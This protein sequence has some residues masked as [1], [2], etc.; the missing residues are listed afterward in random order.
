MIQ[1]REHFIDLFYAEW[2]VLLAKSLLTHWSQN[3]ANKLINHTMLTAYGN[4]FEFF[5]HRRLT[6]VTLIL[7]KYFWSIL[8]WYD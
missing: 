2:V 8:R 6:L 4:R 1:R 3:I 7:F 5:G